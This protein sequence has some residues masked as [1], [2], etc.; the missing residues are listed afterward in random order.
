[1]SSTDTDRHCAKCGGHLYSDAHAYYGC[2]GFQRL[3]IEE[4]QRQLQA[5]TA[6]VDV[7]TRLAF[8]L[9]NES[10]LPPDLKQPNSPPASTSRDLFNQAR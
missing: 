2:V 7:L 3:Q 6:R 4:N 5:M 9:W 8:L 1:M 10:I